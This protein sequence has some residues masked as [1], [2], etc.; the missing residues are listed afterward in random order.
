MCEHEEVRQGLENPAKEFS[1]TL[2]L[3][4]YCSSEIFIK[5][6]LSFNC[7]STCIGTLTQCCSPHFF[8]LLQ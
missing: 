3:I 2:I 4:S 6:T 1:E 7:N 5:Y 8:M